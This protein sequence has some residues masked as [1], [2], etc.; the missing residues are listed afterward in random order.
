MMR[1]RDLPTAEVLDDSEEFADRYI[2]LIQQ[3]IELEAS[4]NSYYR[5]LFTEILDEEL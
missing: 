4:V 1:V 5:P 2:S 3:L